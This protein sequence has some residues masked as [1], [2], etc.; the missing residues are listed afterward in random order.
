[1]TSHYKRRYQGRAVT[2]LSSG[3]MLLLLTWAPSL[4]AK[5]AQ[6]G[7]PAP[8]LDVTWIKDGP[9]KLAKGKIYI[10]DFWATWCVPCLETIPHLT[11]LQ[12]KYKDK[13]VVIVGISTEDASDVK[14]FVDQM[15][16][17]MGYAV[18]VDK[19]TPSTDANGQKGEVFVTAAGYA[20]AF[21]V[22]SIPHSFIVDKQGR[23]V[24][25]G[26]PNDDEMETVL[27]QVIDGKF[28]LDAYKE[29]QKREADRRQKAARAL[30]QYFSAVTDP[31]HKDEALDLGQQI[32]KDY[33]DLPA[34]LNAL[35]WNIMMS[36]RVPDADRDLGLALRAARLA[37]TASKGRPETLDTLAM[38]LF[39]TGDAAEAAKTEEKALEGVGNDDELKAQLTEHLKTFREPPAPTPTPEP[40]KPA[41][42][43]P[44]DT[45][46]NKSAAKTDDTR[47]DAEKRKP[48]PQ[49]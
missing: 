34:P 4:W 44:A 17:K 11:A 26:D 14:P 49:Q 10:I 5:E 48:Q 30:I 7:D 20:G 24:W 9:I 25:H 28:D 18:A 22:D 21:G 39:K 42:T 1:M 2:A 38:A 16:K 32:L 12:A 43:K 29:V 40:V 36:P 41:E 45:K 37:N 19:K 15:D 47:K 8:K 33:A 6:L 31:A 46:T 13:G 35:A 3:L 27:G 23:I